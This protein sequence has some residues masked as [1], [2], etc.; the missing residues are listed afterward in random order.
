M[1]DQ[2]GATWMDRLPWVM[3]GKRTAYQPAL[4]CT[5]SDMVYGGNPTIPGD[6]IGEP[7]PPLT[8]EDRHHLLQTLQMNADRAPTQTVHNRTPAINYP[9]LSNITHVYI[10]KGKT[11][12]LGPK[13]EGPFKIIE[14]VSQSCIKVRVGTT[15]AGQPRL[16]TQHWSNCKPVTLEEGQVEGSRA[17]RGRKP[18]DPKAKMFK[19]STPPPFNTGGTRPPPPFPMAKDHSAPGVIAPKTQ[20][21]TIN[22]AP[23][24]GGGGAQATSVHTRSAHSNNDVP[25]GGGGQEA[26]TRTRT[27]I[28]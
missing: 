12:V 18:L 22:D 28:I 4:D 7:G 27:R 16:E 26:V 3:L 21:R 14:R 15:A 17:T 8:S 19:P 9:D 23:T 24:N 25:S 10:K 20:T 6:L 5:A 11:A 1:G 13:F 2:H